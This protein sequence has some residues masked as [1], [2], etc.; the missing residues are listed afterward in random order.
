M[1]I[2][3]KWFLSLLYKITI[4]IY[5]LSISCF[6]FSVF[7]VSVVQFHWVI[8]A[9]V[10]LE[11][12]S[13]CIIMYLDCS[14]SLCLCLVWVAQK[15]IVILMVSRCIHG[16]IS[17][18]HCSVLFL[19][20]NVSPPKKILYYLISTWFSNYQ[21]LHWINYHVNEIKIG[22]LE[23]PLEIKLWIRIIERIGKMK[24]HYV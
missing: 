18:T 24:D 5:T 19:K 3:S 14:M 10:F 13:C 1:F 6:C 16:L 7:S 21:S 9:T 2:A 17:F 11:A 22:T 23:A 20:N 4:Y 15:L 12:S 8:C